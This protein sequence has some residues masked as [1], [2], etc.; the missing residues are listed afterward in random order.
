MKTY[1]GLMGWVGVILILGGLVWSLNERR[2]ETHETA[3]GA[4]TEIE[5][6]VESPVPEGL[7]EE[8]WYGGILTTDPDSPAS[9]FAAAMNA[10]ARKFDSGAAGE[11]VFFAQQNMFAREFGEEPLTGPLLQPADFS[12]DYRPQFPPGDYHLEWPPQQ[13][14]GWGDR[15]FPPEL[16]R[17]RRP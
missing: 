3:P 4:Q 14:P 15:P 11:A 6:E 17:S 16:P 8:D 1:W 5:A 12:G 10:R 2:G 9:V 13:I 7:A